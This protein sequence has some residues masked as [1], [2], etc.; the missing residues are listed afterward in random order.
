MSHPPN[1]ISIG[2]AVFAHAAYAPV[3][4]THKQTQ[5]IHSDTKTSVA[6]RPIHQNVS[7]VWL[8]GPHETFSRNVIDFFTSHS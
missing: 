3:C 7:T 2:S 8:P 1:G 4:P 6:M 5:D